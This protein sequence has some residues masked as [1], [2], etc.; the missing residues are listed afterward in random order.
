MEFTESEFC[1]ILEALR[2]HKDDFSDFGRE[3]EDYVQGLIDR[4]ENAYSEYEKD[5][6]R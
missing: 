6:S 5:N 2:R 1:T 3:Y 4:F